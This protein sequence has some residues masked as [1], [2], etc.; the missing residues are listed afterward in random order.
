MFGNE[1]FS[2]YWQLW[3]LFISIKS[4][5]SILPDSS[6]VIVITY[7]LR[8]RFTYS[9]KPYIH[10]G[11]I[12]KQL[13]IVENIDVLMNSTQQIRRN[14]ICYLLLWINVASEP[15]L[16]RPWTISESFHRSSVKI[17]KMHP[18]M[19]A[20]RGFLRWTKQITITT[21]HFYHM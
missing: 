18:P 12:D 10:T 15:F 13:F 6:K 17:I 19:S 5:E 1:H 16:V 4:V 21:K 2:F 14:S 7:L 11:Y 3:L 8:F 20:F 9:L